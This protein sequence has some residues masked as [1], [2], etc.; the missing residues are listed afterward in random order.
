MEHLSNIKLVPL[1]QL[2]LFDVDDSFYPDE[3]IFNPEKRDQYWKQILQ[4]HG[5]SGMEAIKKGEELIPVSE[6]HTEVLQQLIKWFLQDWYD[7]EWQNGKLSF[8]KLQDEEFERP[9]SFYGGVM[10]TSEDRIMICSQCCVS[11]QDHQEWMQLES[12]ASFK[13]I[14]I[15]HPWI[16][17]KVK[18]DKILFTRL[19]EKELT[20]ET[21]RHYIS[22]DNS[23]LRDFSNFEAKPQEDIDDRD[24][25]YS[26]NYEAFKRATENLQEELNAFKARIE[27][28]LIEAGTKNP[29]EVADCLV[30]GNGIHLSYSADE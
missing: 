17:Y 1:I 19:I 15:G 7:F 13:R 30:N 18:G 22:A 9:T 24:L 14:W 10:M 12:S 5:F 26:V 29:A 6:F 2:S 16:Y 25:K 27:K 4:K 20:G 3:I 23:L 11:L 21:W 8:V 28:I